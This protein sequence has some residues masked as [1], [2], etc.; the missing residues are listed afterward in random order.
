M[1]IDPHFM[2]D[3]P[4]MGPKRSIR[5]YTPPMTPPNHSTKTPKSAAAPPASPTGPPEGAFAPA[6]PLGEA[7]HF[8]RMEGVV[9][10]RS[11]LTAPWGL[12]LPP[13]PDCVLFHVVTAGE[14][15]LETEGEEPRRLRP[16]EFTLVPH[17][18]GHRIRDTL[19]SPLD[20]LFD[21]PRE[22]YGPHYEVIRHG[23]GGALTRLVCGAVRFGHPA[24][25]ELVAHLPRVIQISSWDAA[26]TPQA[27]AQRD[28]LQSTLRLMAA[29]SGAPRPGGETVVTR[30]ADIL[31][32][33]SIRAW[34]EDARSREKDEED[35]AA[36][37]WLRAIHDERIGPTLLAMQRDPAHDWSVASLARVARLSRSAFAA[38]FRA[39]VGEGPLA[40]LTRW[41]MNTAVT[42]LEEGDTTVGEVAERLGYRSEA[43]FGR[44][45]KR[46]VGESP[47]RVK[48]RAGSGDHHSQ[49]P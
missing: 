20:H 34:L 2:L 19:D 42:W 38:R 48:R 1:T 35:A 7:L 33:Q 45:F 39:L 12:D 40:Y 22:E 4:A 26:A 6:D 47:G 18:E 49:M 30:L 41:R 46:V 10:S 14:C 23:G 29:E 28:W 27:A 37:G 15:W 3:R 31:V 24:A 11:E 13:L 43:A 9:Y 16:G 44:A 17:G 36:V 5:C 32:I 25:R 8:L 21:V